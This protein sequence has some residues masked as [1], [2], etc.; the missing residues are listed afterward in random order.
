MKIKYFI[1]L[2]FIYAGLY[3]QNDQAFSL[4]TVIP[5]SPE[6]GKLIEAGKLSAGLHT[7]SANVSIPLFSFKKNGSVINIAINYNS[8]GIKVDDIP[9]RV[10]LG[11]NLLAGGV[12]S[13]IIRNQPDDGSAPFLNP[14]ANP[15][16]RNLELLNYLQAVTQPLPAFDTEWDEYSYSFNG[17]SGRF[18]LDD[19]GNGVPIPHSNVKIRVYGLNTS[20][21]YFEITSAD[22][23]RY[24]FGLQAKETTRSI[25]IQGGTSGKVIKNA[26]YETSWFLDKVLTP[27]GGEINFNYSSVDIVNQTGKY[28]TLIKPILP[29]SSC[30]GQEAIKC[31]YSE[32]SGTNVIEYRSRIIESI[33]T[34]DVHIDFTYE[35]RPDISGDKR[36]TGLTVYADDI[37]RPVKSFTFE[38]ETPEVNNS[39][40]NRRFFLKR[41]RENDLQ[42]TTQS[43]IDHT[44][45]YYDINGMPDRLSYSQDWYGYYNGQ[46]NTYFAPYIAHIAGVVE[47][48]SN[49]GNRNPGTLDQMQKGSLSTV[50]YPTGGTES[51]EYE[52]HTINRDIGI[53]VME[54]AST[55]GSGAGINSPMVHQSN[56]FTA[57]SNQQATIFLSSYKSPA[58][59]DDPSGEG[60]KIFH[61]KVIDIQ[62]G[63][64][65]F[66]RF[67]YKYTT[68]QF[69]ISLSGNKSY[70]L[71]L[72]IWGQVNAGSVNIHFNHAT[73]LNNENVAV[74]GIRVKAIK[75]F[76]PVT[77]KY[78]NKFY[79]YAFAGDLSKSSGVGQFFPVL[80]EQNING[81]GLC[82]AGT[83]YAS[84]LKCN[85]Y[86]VSS[87]SVG[88]NY[89]FAGSNVGYA[90]VIEYNDPD[91][92]NG[93]TQHLFHT[94]YPGTA[95]PNII[96]GTSPLGT[97]VFLDTDMN[98]MEIQTTI[99]KRSV[100][101]SFFPIKEVINNYIISDEV[102]ESRTSYL[103]RHRYGSI[104]GSVTT[105]GDEIFDGFDLVR[106]NYASKWVQLQST[107]EHTYDENGGNPVS[108][109]KSFTY[110]NKTHMQPTTET[111]RNSKNELLITEYKY[112][113][114]FAVN[115]PGNVYQKMVNQN[116]LLE[117]VEVRKYKNSIS[118]LNL[119]EAIR[120]DYRDWFDN[121][122]IIMPEWIK[123]KYKNSLDWDNRIQFMEV[124][125]NGN[126]L[127]VRKANDISE[128]YIWGY[129]NSLPVAKAVGT[130]VSG[131]A[132]TSFED[133]DKGNWSYN[134]T[135]VKSGVAF[136]GACA[137][138]LASGQI[139]RLIADA[140]TYHISYWSKGGQ[141]VIPG[142]SIVNQAESNGWTFFDHLM[143]LAAPTV[144]SVSSPVQLIIDELR[145][146]PDKSQL[147]TFTH[148]PFVGISSQN[149][150]NNN[151]LLF[152][153]DGHNRL[154]N[155]RN[156]YGDILKQYEYKYQVNIQGNL[157]TDPDWQPTGIVRCIQIP[158]NNNYNGQQEAEEKDMNP[159]SATYQQVR[160]IPSGT[161]PVCNPVAD[162]TGPDKRVV[163]NLCETGQKKIVYSIFLNGVWECKYY[164]QW[165]DGFRSID[166]MGYNG[167]SCLGDIQ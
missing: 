164:Y 137:Y 100:A 107:I 156:R 157:S 101:G 27:E 13:R 18:F 47:G 109:V 102:A 125:S 22:G 112:P 166:Y 65:I 123:S 15:Y 1:F 106:Y 80:F 43:S 46:P 88:Q 10:G 17:I 4:P 20:S 56:T 129:N 41:I 38:Y 73:N 16:E 3:S 5:P 35:N 48:G 149:D 94:S 76:D 139:T 99:F 70:R 120:T 145:L 161:A 67:Y 9:S 63:A 113:I 89:S 118:D 72:T 21:K 148:R 32:S 119:L 122:K 146:Y 90:S 103:A 61:A 115:A 40:W 138:D 95:N 50:F 92:K 34:D 68:E 11:W 55:N 87:G 150:A 82:N 96:M 29:I 39:S 62:S 23:I 152:T 59:P 110:G 104:V 84:V 45:S 60:D 144:I 79:K 132:F 64:I 91:L 30:P 128:S 133:L 121:G 108:V 141:A 36:L 69:T 52:P 114:D 78:T 163:N 75:S 153:Y 2:I 131:I 37:T 54:S 134:G 71:E 14:P 74:G 24:L 111:V 97:P 66:Q 98:G 85:S 6:V 124:S 136:T 25:N 140:G 155:I 117:K 167:T 42:S 160:Y 142:T 151:L 116:K 143:N 93:F 12:V 58:F 49:G 51:F 135:P 57:N 53:P 81:G 8:N 28:Q 77:G 83:L 159:S 7:G 19:N 44:F 147:S 26:A 33:F 154:F 165:S 158:P 105:P 130:S 162:C 31:S 127:E 126:I 86:T